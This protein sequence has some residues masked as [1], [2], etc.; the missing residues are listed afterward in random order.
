MSKTLIIALSS[1]VAFAVYNAAAQASGVRELPEAPGKTLI[2]TKCTSCHSIG[3]IARA[4]GYSSEEQ[5]LHLISTMIE[6][7][8]DEAKVVATYLSEHVP[9]DVSRRPTL[10]AGDTAIEIKEWITPTLGQRTRDPIEAPDGS[11][12]WTGMWASLAGR[13]D[14]ET[15]EMKEY[16][17]PPTAR[18]HSILPDADGNI[19]YTGNSNATIGKLDPATGEVKEYATEAGDPHTAVF[20]PNGKLYFTAQRAGMLGRLDPESGQLTEIETRA[21]PYGIKVGPDGS[22]WVAYNGTNALSKMD[23]DSMEVTYFDV[24]DERTRIRRLD[25]DS[26]GM[27]WFV[28]SSL[29]KVGRLDPSTGEIKQW[30]SPSGEKSHPYSLAVIDDAVWYNESAMRPDALVRFDPATETFQS[31][32]IPSG[33]GIIRHTWVTRTGDLL[34]HQTSSNR[35]GVVKILEQ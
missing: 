14:P 34:I 17:L 20:H 1:F 11:I 35:V 3:T 6:L 30:D 21:R 33:V 2:E 5:W 4:A 23:P 18:P 8:E 7:P 27:V 15:G 25:L 31:W 26:K 16:P 28:N 32:A 19:W 22:L 24:P 9:E 12:W 29:G 13:L 10:V